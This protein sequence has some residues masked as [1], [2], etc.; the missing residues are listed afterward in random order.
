M[1]DEHFLEVN[2]NYK[3]YI[4]VGLSCSWGTTT[5]CLIGTCVSCEWIKHEVIHVPLN[6]F[7]FDFAT[8]NVIVLMHDIY[9]FIFVYHN[10]REMLI[11][12]TWFAISCNNQI[13]YTQSD[14]N[15]LLH[16]LIIN[17]KYDVDHIYS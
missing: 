1:F 10:T 9:Y 16:A 17:V 12:Y 14:A 13:C 5:S 6:I 2:V 3:A 8:Y 11:L 4:L 15:I 7:C